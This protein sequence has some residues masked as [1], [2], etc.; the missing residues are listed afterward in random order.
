MPEIGHDPK[1]SPAV[2]DHKHDSIRAIMRR[3]NSLHSYTA[4]KEPRSLVE[5]ADSRNDAQIVPR[6]RSRACPFGDIKAHGSYLV[7][8]QQRI[9]G[10]GGHLSNFESAELLSRPAKRRLQWVCLAH[11]SEENNTPAHAIGTHRQLLGK[12]FPL[13]VASRY[14]SR[15]V[16]EL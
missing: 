3:R 9:R 13:L 15:D 10:P 4:K 7:H 14:A 2:V 1:P 8:L 5:E 11:L 16:L 12:R 6:L